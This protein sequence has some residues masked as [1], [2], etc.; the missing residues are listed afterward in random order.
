MA[1][2]IGTA[3]H[4]D[5]GKTTLIQAL[6]GID[7][8]RLPEEKERG[9]T[10]DIG[11]AHIDLPGHGQV[12]IVDVPGHQKFVTNMLV[13]ALGIDVALLCVAADAG[14]MPQTREHLQILD[15]LPVDSLVVAMTR[16]DLADETTRELA[17]DEVRDL[18]ASTRFGEVPIV[19]TS[20][21]TGEGVEKLKELL[22]AALGGSE[23]GD[24]SKPWYMPIDRA[25]SVKGHGLVVT[26]SLAQGTV[27]AGSPAVL[28]PGSVAAKVRA[29]HAHGVQVEASE[30]G[31]RSALNL[32]G[33][34]LEDVHRGMSIGADGVLFETSN[35]DARIRWVGPHRHGQRVRV[36]IGA[37]EGIARLFLNDQERD[38][39]QLRFDRPVAAALGQPLIMRRYSPPDVIAGG[40]VVVPQATPRR[41]KEKALLVSADTTEEGIIEAVGKDPN[42]VR[43]EEVCRRLGKTPQALGD[44]FEKLRTE[45]RLLGFAGL[46]LTPEAFDAGWQA[47]SQALSD[48]HD[49]KPTLAFVP[50][51]QVVHRAGLK[52]AGK[53]LDRILARL[54]EE[55]RIETQGTGVRNAS[56]RVRLTPRQRE[57]LDRVVSVLQSEP[58]N[59]PSVD[60]IARAVPIPIQAAEE[61]LRIGTHAGEV[62]SIGEG[63]YYTAQ[64]F[65]TLK[66]LVRELA[67]GKP[68]TAAEMRD[69]L[70]TSR[71]YVIPLLEYLDSIRFTARVGEK[72]VVQ[73]PR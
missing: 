73:D 56:F 3:G 61:I 54:A 62:L 36:S 26:G 57:L 28:Q 53:H 35:L 12:S 16:S 4:V 60:E 59:V 17:A 9:L 47:F 10:I 19:F 33:P 64:Q 32:S 24:V 37:D 50:R 66:A 42:G 43:T 7:A 14:V 72:R 65:E 1:K 5:H 27:Q 70:G 67:G 51:E 69:A 13:G 2:L 63:I 45:G 18:M 52:W 20:A 58:V 21:T 11:F 8:D 48:A 55:G 30:T 44:A 31:R 25:F 41:R 40:Q 46:W 34:K 22:T 15:L 29:V 23:Q 38:V 49:A 39:V 68:F 71:K 6:T